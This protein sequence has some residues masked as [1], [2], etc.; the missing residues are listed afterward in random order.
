MGR[1]ARDAGLAMT[2]QKYVI[3]ILPPSGK[4]TLGVSQWEMQQAIRAALLTLRHKKHQLGHITVASVE[5]M[6]GS[7]VCAVNLVKAIKQEAEQVACNKIDDHEDDHVAPPSYN[8]Y[9]Y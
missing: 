6:E 5:P 4:A 7:L 9:D 8:Y 1:T 3:E 2:A